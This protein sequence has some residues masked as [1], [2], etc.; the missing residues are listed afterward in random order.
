MKHVLESL[1]AIPGV[2]AAALVTLDGVPIV[3][4]EPARGRARRA[5]S[6]ADSNQDQESRSQAQAEDL[7]GPANFAADLEALAGLATGWMGEITRA[8][9]P[10]SWSPPQRLVLRAA[11]GTLVSLQAPGALLLVVLESGMRAEELR[12]PMEVVVAR[13]QRHLR[14]VDSKRSKVQQSIVEPPGIFPASSSTGSQGV[15]ALA[16]GID[17]VHS[18]GHTSPEVSGE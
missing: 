17:V 18:I 9:A 15:N 13:M 14:D 16:L 1:G 8:V 4:H 11:R 2:R 3:V 6:D 7:I 12:L 5:R 10:L